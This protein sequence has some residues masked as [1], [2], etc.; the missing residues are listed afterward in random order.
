MN[1]KDLKNIQILAEFRLGTLSNDEAMKQITFTQ[2]TESGRKRYLSKLI[3][4]IAQEEQKQWES[5][6]GE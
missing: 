2:K 1:K 6:D 4:L 3:T 5:S